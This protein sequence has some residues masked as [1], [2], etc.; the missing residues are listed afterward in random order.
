MRNG[1]ILLLT[2]RNLDRVLI[3]KNKKTGLWMIP[4]GQPSPGDQNSLHTAKRE[5][6][7][8]V[9]NKHVPR[10]AVQG[11]K[12]EVVGRN[13]RVHTDIYLFFD[14]NYDPRTSPIKSGPIINN[15]VSEIKFAKWNDIFDYQ[16]ASYVKNSLCEMIE[17]FHHTLRK[18][19]RF[20]SVCQ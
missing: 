13:G 18:P 19:E 17:K 10:S 6:K 5:F 2:G 8:E 3:V 12:Y 9:D 7:E 15:E 20:Y 14:V 16:F 1:A 11:P 4:G